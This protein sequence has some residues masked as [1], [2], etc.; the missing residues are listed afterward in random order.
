M[1]LVNTSLTNAQSN[2]WSKRFESQAALNKNS[3]MI[4]PKIKIVNLFV[5][6]KLPD[7]P[8]AIARR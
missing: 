7:L 6:R 1:V 5:W 8:C 2:F 3:M 4:T